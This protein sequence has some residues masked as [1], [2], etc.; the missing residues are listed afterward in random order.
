MTIKEI[1][2]KKQNYLTITNGTIELTL[3]KD[4]G[5]RI[6][7]AGFEN[8]INLFEEVNIS[9]KTPYGIWKI[10]GGHRLWIAPE[11]FPETYMPDNE[12][13]NIKNAKDSITISAQVKKLNI[14]KEIKLKFIHKNKIEV[15]QSIKNNGRKNMQLSIW[16]LSV[17][18]KGGFAIIPQNKKKEDKE[19]MLPN[20]NIILWPYSDITDKRLKLSNKYI[21]VKQGGKKPFKIGQRVPDNWAAY[22]YKGYMFIK[23]FKFNPNET[24]P[25]FNSNVEIYSC[26][27]FLELE[28]LS[29]LYTIKPGKSVSQTEIW[30]FKKG[31]KQPTLL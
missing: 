5:P 15:K 30:E 28:T 22:Y 18:R 4:Y 26:D 8:D 6:I 29:P 13:V 1:T 20:R 14:V 24:Y 3:S 23:H 31:V 25:D 16:G 11:K 27:K 17:M 7:R 12:P 19:G 10:Y 2:L 21:F 9:R